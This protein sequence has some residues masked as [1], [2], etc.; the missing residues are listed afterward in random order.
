MIHRV[1]QAIIQASYGLIPAR[2]SGQGITE[3][4]LILALAMVVVIVAIAVLG[5]RTGALI[6][7]SVASLS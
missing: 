6:N 4:G 2:V 5:P 3:Y 1:R 7:R